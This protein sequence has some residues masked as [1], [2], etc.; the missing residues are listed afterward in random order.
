MVRSLAGDLSERV[1]HVLRAD[2]AAGVGDDAERPVSSLLAR[3]QASHAT[4]LV[5][6]LRRP[7]REE[8]HRRHGGY[9]HRISTLS[10]AGPCTTGR[11]TCVTT[12]ASK[13]ELA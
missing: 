10:H 6:A 5:G 3:V 7:V 9:H 4:Q 12:L 8:H 2:S 11:P 13:V 1:L